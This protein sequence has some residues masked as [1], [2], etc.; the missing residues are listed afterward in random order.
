[1]WIPC[2]MTVCEK[3]K[4]RCFVSNFLL[5][6]KI[7]WN[8]FENPK[9][10]EIFHS[11]FTRRRGEMKENEEVDD[12]GRCY[13]WNRNF[14]CDSRDF[15]ARFSET[16]DRAKQCILVSLA[17]LIRCPRIYFPNN[18][19]ISPR[20]IRLKPCEN[21]SRPRPRRSLFRAAHCFRSREKLEG[22][23]VIFN[24]TQMMNICWTTHFVTINLEHKKHPSYPISSPRKKSLTLF[25]LLQNQM[26][27][28]FSSSLRRRMKNFHLIA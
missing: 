26:W 6:E 14:E 24:V 10:M 8:W 25:K 28:F 3:R 7:N 13:V 21:N 12:D 22:R 18:L 4:N 2:R 20:L 16:A 11:K 19:L 1:M 27:F 5:V 15:D 23:F 17:L 9:I